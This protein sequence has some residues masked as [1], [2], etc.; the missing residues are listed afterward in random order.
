LARLRD[1]GLRADDITSMVG[2]SGGPK[3]LVLSQLD[4]ALHPLVVAD[5]TTPLAVLGSSIGTFRH[6]CHAQRDWRAAIE[7][8]EAAYI[9][10]AYERE[11][12]PGEVSA[13][14]RRVLDVLFGTTGRRDVLANELVR[15]HIVVARSLWPVASDAR[16]PLTLGLGAAAIANTASRRL[17]AGFFARVVFHSPNPAFRF[18]GFGTT[19]VP[20]SL[21]NLDAAALASGS[22]PLVMDGV[23]RIVGA[24]PGP[25]RDGGIIDYH[26]DFEFE[27]G[28]GLILYPHFFDRITPGWFDKALSWRRARGA[29]LDRT[30]LIAPS[31]AFVA[32]L[33]GG[34]VPDRDD[35]RGLSTA[36]R[37]RRWVAVVAQCR[38]LADELSELWARGRLGAVARPFD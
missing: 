20:L 32:T 24:P 6:L 7:R 8:F 5:R 38:V 21:A 35:F 15:T 36:E 26:F 17:L 18:D 1:G 3:W 9:A 12:T 29:T 11:P 4:R 31:P 30:V 10:Q 33:P 28:E 19:E 34:K 14:S 25:H 22:I 37:Q 23:D 27:A 16:V 2:A 13:E